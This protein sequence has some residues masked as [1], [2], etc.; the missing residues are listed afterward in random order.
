MSDSSPSPLISAKDLLGLSKPCERLIEKI[1]DAIGG[2]TRPRQIIRIAAAEAEAEVIRAHASVQIADI[3]RRAALRFEEEEANYQRNMENTLK[4]ALPHI[5]EG[6]KPEDID[7]DWITYF[8]SKVRIVSGEQMQALW[9]G[10]LAEEANRPGAFSKRCLS[11][12]EVMSKKDAD[13]FTAVGRFACHFDGQPWLVMFDHRDSIYASNGITH[14]RIVQLESLGLIARAKTEFVNS[15]VR[16]DIHFRYFDQMVALKNP[17][18]QPLPV[19]Q[20]LL[21][22]PGAELLSICH[23]EKV[24]GFFEYLMNYWSVKTE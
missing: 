7:L 18:M 5:Q 1:A 21:T 23:S 14:D 16:T 2:L 19:G 10:I 20:L 12:I 6:A 3:Q 22:S 15:G 24:P 9:A 11:I 17:S 4:R 13:A 8:F